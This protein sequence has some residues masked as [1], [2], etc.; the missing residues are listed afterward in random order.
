MRCRVGL[1]AIG[2]VLL[3]RVDLIKEDL[4]GRGWIPIPFK[5]H[6]VLGEVVRGNPSVGVEEV[7][8][9]IPCRPVAVANVRLAQRF[10]VDLVYSF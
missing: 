9:N 3:V 7:L 8:Q 6:V 4:N 2:C 1:F 5:V 10:D